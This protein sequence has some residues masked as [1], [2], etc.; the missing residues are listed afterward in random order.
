[1]YL[2]NEIILAVE[3]GVTLGLLKLIYSSD[4]KFH[5]ILQGVR[6]RDASDPTAVS[7]VILS[8]DRVLDRDE[9]ELIIQGIIM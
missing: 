2:N 9:Y 4:T 5:G 6:S 7:S 8:D 1:M 3:H